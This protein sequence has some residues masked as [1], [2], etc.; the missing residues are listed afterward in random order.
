MADAPILSLP[1]KPFFTTSAAAVV[2]ADLQGKILV[3][4][5]AF[6]KLVG[7][8]AAKMNDRPILNFIASE[9]SQEARDRL[10]AL[11]QDN[12][13]RDEF[14]TLLLHVN[15]EKLPI[16]LGLALVHDASD[17]PLCL[18][19]TFSESAAG[20]EKRRVRGPVTS[21][22][23]E[24]LWSQVLDRIPQSLLLINFAHHIEG[25][26]KHAESAFGYSKSELRNRPVEKLFPDLMGRIPEP[27]A[28]ASATRPPTAVH[29][30]H[31]SGYK[32]PL[33][34]DLK[35]MH[36]DNGFYWLGIAQNPASEKLIDEAGKSSYWRELASG[37]YNRML[38]Q[39]QL[40]HAIKRATREDEILGILL[41]SLDRFNQ[42]YE[43]VGPEMGDQLLAEAGTRI[44]EFVRKS[45]CVIQMGENRHA[46][47][48]E[49]IKQAEHISI[50]TQKLSNAFLPPFKC[51][52]GEVFI[53]VSIGVSVFPVDGGDAEQLIK[54][55][56]SAMH[57]VIQEGGSSFLF[58]TP[59][60]HS[61][62]MERMQME[63]ELRRA[64]KNEEFVVHYQ[65]ILNA[66]GDR[67]TCLEA[68]VRWNHP[69][70]GL[71]PPAA[72][73]PLLEETGLI[74]PV[75]EWVLRSACQ[76]VNKL[77]SNGHAK[78]RV[79][80][81]LSARQ[82]MQQDFIGT[83]KSILQET[84]VDPQALDLEITESVLIKNTD[85][86]WETLKA[87]AACG[88]SIV[89]DDFG[90]GCSSL[91][92]LKRFPIHTLK[93]DR[94]FVKGLPDQRGDMAITD[95]ILVLAMKL[96]LRVVAEGVETQAQLDYL[97]SRDCHEMQGFLFARPM[98]MAEVGPWLQRKGR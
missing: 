84:Q 11:A 71:V 27:G 1:F 96:G 68:L 18:M 20:T 53:S 46:I 16:T 63:N 9:K 7:Q 69:Q 89:L 6:L 29:A 55:A 86:N 93:I 88:V 67:I 83:L 79:S 74:A 65:P 60:L 45:D 26:N 15:G 31:K 64:L 58:Y 77:R 33:L 30:M 97:R 98:P 40:G 85:E 43:S 13:G 5:P 56:E 49:G 34:L 3:A 51:N 21:L 78:L 48:L 94:N 17:R 25:I 38:F 28:A 76:Y 75:G 2:L 32:I 87:V 62:A 12:R 81:N 42:L 52:N 50:V 57:Q 22:T 8:S 95:A 47:L 14:H 90:T 72:F 59:A 44:A 73:I 36:F 19:L 39:E 70:K 61:R 37:L 35:P 92:Y 80:V 4:N 41:L 10:D 24:D 23:T 66:D 82:F 91:S 54:N